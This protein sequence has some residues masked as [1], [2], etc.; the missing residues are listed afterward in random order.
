MSS[1]TPKRKLTYE[2]LLKLPEDDKRHEIIDGVHYVMSSPVLRHQRLVRRVGVSIIN[3]L[4]A[5][6]LGEA[7]NLAVDVVLSPHDVVVPDL[8]YV[9]KERSHLL[10][11]KN[12]P[13]PPDLVV[14]VLS[15]STSHKDR[16]L[17][18]RLYEKAGVLEYWMMNGD[19]DTVRVYRLGPT[20]YGTGV[21]LSAAAGDI[22][23]TPLLPGWKL[24]LSE[25]FRR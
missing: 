22:L 4:E 2:D 8:V 20:G 17:K 7:F 19:D 13:G 25:L 1:G 12:I 21:H 11:E 6:G 16:K 15:P 10:Q 23:T 3:F 9:S 5:A 14:E 24:P 18:R